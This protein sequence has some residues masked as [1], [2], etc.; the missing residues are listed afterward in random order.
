MNASE[1]RRLSETLYTKCI[2]ND[3]ERIYD[4]IAHAA[5]KGNRTVAIENLLPEEYILNNRV[6]EHLKEVDGYIVKSLS[7]PRGD[8]YVNVSW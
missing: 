6:I 8:H 2:K 3:L 4:A 5:K 7:D 1:A